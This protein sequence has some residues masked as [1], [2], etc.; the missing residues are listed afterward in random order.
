MEVFGHLSTGERDL[1]NAERTLGFGSLDSRSE[2]LNCIPRLIRVQNDVFMA[3]QVV[4]VYGD[5]PEADRADLAVRKAYTRYSN[6]SQC[7]AGGRRPKKKRKYRYLERT[8]HTP[9][10]VVHCSQWKLRRR[11]RDTRSEPNDTD[12]WEWFCP[13]ISML[14]AGNARCK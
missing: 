9:A 12:D 14:W 6:I 3:L 2:S 8:P 13:T 7:L 5:V 11:C 1:R 4:S 10:E